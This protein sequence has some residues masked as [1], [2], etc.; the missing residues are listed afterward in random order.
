MIPKKGEIELRIKRPLVAVAALSL[1]VAVLGACSSSSKSSSSGGST[2]SSSTGSAAPTGQPLEVN[3]NAPLTGPINFPEV[4]AGVLAAQDAVNAAGGVHHRPLKVIFCDGQS[5]TDPTPTLNCTHSAIANQSVV[6][7]VGDYSSFGSL[8]APLLNAAGMASIAPVPLYAPQYEL[9]NSFPLMASEAGAN[10]VCVADQGAKSVG[11]AYIDIP[12]SAEQITFGNAFLLKGR[13][14]T[15]AK[16]VPI[17][18]TVTDP[19]PQVTALAPYGGVALGLA[20]T[21]VAQYL[22]AHKSVAPNQ[23][24]CDAYLSATPTTLQSLGSAANGLY[25]VAGLPFVESNNPG[26]AVFKQQMAQYQPGATVDEPALNAWL[27]VTAFAQ[28]ANQTSGDVT[29]ASVLHAWQSLTSL[30]VDGLLPPDLNMQSSP[31][32]IPSLARLVNVWVQ[33]GRV[34][35]G[36]INV[37]TQNFVDLLTKP[38]S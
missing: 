33:Y 22:E 15:Y 34:E 10:G 5:P 3:I 27:S 2:P 19:T 8:V 12:G 32:G 14:M 24:V 29:R 16:S 23:T 38:T 18:L 1:G 35:S 9:P 26:V 7:E 6:A 17:S 28:V 4:K 20:P 31:L 30:Q 13:G 37:L 36:Q 25:L 21:Q 11:F